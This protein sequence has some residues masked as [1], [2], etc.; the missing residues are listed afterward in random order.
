[1]S[2]HQISLHTQFRIKSKHYIDNAR[3]YK[4]KPPRVVITRVFHAHRPTVGLSPKA[5]C[6]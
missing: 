2:K 1:M 6:R 4:P 5:P 3:A